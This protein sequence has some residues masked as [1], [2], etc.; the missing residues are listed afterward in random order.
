MNTND[1][2]L[3]SGAGAL[4]ALRAFATGSILSID[5]ALHTANNQATLLRDLLSAQA[6]RIPISLAALIPNIIVEYI[7]NMPVPGTSF[8]GDGHWHIHIRTEDPID[9]QSFTALHEL[10][11][12]IDHPLRR[13]SASV[14]S[15]IDWEVL[16]N[17]F[18]ARVLSFSARRVTASATGRGR[19]WLNP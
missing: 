8:W 15:D 6:A 10:K 11:H 18:A 9:F 16:A 7:D 14:T 19:P 17:H 12:I 5:D 1:A 3:A 13:Q 4:T 2:N